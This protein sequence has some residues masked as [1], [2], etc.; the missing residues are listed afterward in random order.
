[1][2][3]DGNATASPFDV[4]L[5]N[6]LRVLY[7]PMPWL[8]TLSVTLLMPFGSV[9]DPIG[10]EGSASVLHEWLQRGAG[11][12]D[13]R[14]LSDAFEDLGVRRGG[15]AGRETST[16]GA[17]FLAG[18]AARALP[19]L[20]DMVKRP[21]FE[22]PEFAPA[23]ELAQ[24]ELRSLEDAPTQKMFEALTARFLASPHRRSSLGTPEGLAALTEAGV[25]A[26]AANR[27]GPD[28]A[29]LALAGGSTWEQLLPVIEETFGTWRGATQPVPAPELAPQGLHHVDAETT[30]LQVG[31]AY[32]SAQVGTDEGYLYTLALNVLSG[33]MGARLFTEIREKRGLV[34]SV[35]AGTRALRGLGFTVGYAGTTTERAAETLQVFLA[36]LDRLAEGVTAEELERSRTGLLSSVVMRG[37]S[38]GATAGRL[39]TDAYYLGRARTLAEV[40]DKIE[41]ATLEQVNEY[42]AANPVP[43]PTI[44]TLGRLPE[45][46]L[47][48]PA[49]TVTATATEVG[50]GTGTAT[51]TD[52]G[53]EGRA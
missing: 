25:R 23:V 6:G 51:G 43:T 1:M 39:A 31:L 38:S 14:A 40:S 5:P 32:P 41:S 24:E 44:V 28:G 35:S 47:G 10:N 45:G 48:L 52:A 19:L 18:D 17:G 16:L 50:T 3:S 12:L 37:E 4:T 8:P 53:T 15:N 13:S 7:E 34:Y 42:L 49:A 36:E 29:I 9:T 27:L 21:R 22:S 20:A 33:S 30:Q 11:D 46:G 2:P 26:D